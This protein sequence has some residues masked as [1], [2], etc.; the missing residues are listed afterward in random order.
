M[1]WEDGWGEERRTK[2]SILI[3]KGEEKNKHKTTSNFLEFTQ[4]FASKR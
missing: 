3:L 4:S 2:R 1:G